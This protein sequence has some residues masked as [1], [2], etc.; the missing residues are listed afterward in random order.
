MVEWLSWGEREVQRKFDPLLITQLLKPSLGE[1]ISFNSQL[2]EYLPLQPWCWTSGAMALGRLGTALALV[3]QHTFAPL[4]GM[5]EMVPHRRSE[6]CVHLIAWNTFV[7]LAH[8]CSC[9]GIALTSSTSSFHHVWSR[10]VTFCEEICK[11]E[12]VPMSGEW[13]VACKGRSNFYLKHNS[14]LLIMVSKMFTTFI[15]VFPNEFI[16]MLGQN[17]FCLFQDVFLF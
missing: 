1:M 9:K 14:W 5:K 11:K 4:I 7:S 10:M 13:E 15:F 12:V 8:S 17:N 6:D 2:R 16:T 3:S